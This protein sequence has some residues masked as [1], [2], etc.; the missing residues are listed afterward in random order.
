[1]EPRLAVATMGGNEE[2]H[3]DCN[4]PSP[5]TSSP[6]F[7]A[8]SPPGSYFPHI[9]K[10]MEPF[11]ALN[12]AVAVAEFLDFTS[13]LLDEEKNEVYQTSH[14][15]TAQTSRQL[16]NDI[17]RLNDSLKRLASCGSEIGSGSIAE[18]NRVRN[19]PRCQHL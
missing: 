5:L 6:G 14:S 2:P 17:L 18:Y 15:P 9:I 8:R 7:S 4:I 1:M 10:K 3:A 16:T 19:N 13:T 11:H 12:I